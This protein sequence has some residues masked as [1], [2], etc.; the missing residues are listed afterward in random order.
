MRKGKKSKVEVRRKRINIS[1]E[2]IELILKAI[3]KF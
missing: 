2:L 1:K 3:E